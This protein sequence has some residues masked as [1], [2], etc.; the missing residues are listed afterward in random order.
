[1]ESKSTTRASACRHMW[2][3]ANVVSQ[4]KSFSSLLMISLGVSF[5][6]NKSDA[7]QVFLQFK[8]Y[9][10]KQSGHNDK[11]LRTDRGAGSESIFSLE[12][13]FINRQ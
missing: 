11:V 3:N 5:L 12:K 10:E 13:S 4:Q 8:A 1:M 9:V 2:S 6:K 7:F